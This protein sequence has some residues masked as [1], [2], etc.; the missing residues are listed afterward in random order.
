[1]FQVLKNIILFNEQ[2]FYTAHIYE[3][4]SFVTK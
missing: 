2:V 1:M 4:F 3:Q